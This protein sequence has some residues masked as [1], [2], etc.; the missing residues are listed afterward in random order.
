MGTVEFAVGYHDL[1]F[2]LM[3]KMLDI[4]RCLM[5]D[6][7]GLFGTTCLFLGHF[8]DVVRGRGGRKPLGIWGASEPRTC[9]TTWQMGHQEPT[10]L[11]SW[12]GTLVL[13]DSKAGRQLTRSSNTMPSCDLWRQLNR[14]RLRVVRLT[15]WMFVPRSWSHDIK[16]PV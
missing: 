9:K 5:F 7:Q 6:E 4:P 14:L 16:T 12:L 2:D 8:A 1:F 3:C 11:N 10:F 15:L 13:D